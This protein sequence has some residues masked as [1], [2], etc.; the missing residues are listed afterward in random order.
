MMGEVKVG[1]IYLSP[2]GVKYLVVAHS[3]RLGCVEVE[4]LT[5]GDGK[6]DTAVGCL[7]VPQNGW[8]LV[9]SGGPN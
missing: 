5:H 2:Q 3:P 8:H 6:R 7:M 9:P 1:Q 4:N